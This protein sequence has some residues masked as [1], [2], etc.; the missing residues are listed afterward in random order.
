MAAWCCKKS[1]S[2]FE[3]GWAASTPCRLFLFIYFFGSAAASECKAGWGTEGGGSLTCHPLSSRK[4]RRGLFSVSPAICLT[5][6]ERKKNRECNRNWPN[7]KRCRWV[8]CHFHSART[9]LF[10]AFSRRFVT[11]LTRQMESF[12]NR[13]LHLLL[14][15]SFF[16]LMEGSLAAASSCFH[17][18]L[19]GRRLVVEH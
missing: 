16:F 10:I 1:S 13:P 5:E 6:A 19:M 15:V 12:P 7:R 2:V 3:N 4:W 11:I 17:H 9:A 18:S 8:P 14:C